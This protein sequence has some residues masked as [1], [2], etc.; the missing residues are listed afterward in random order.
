MS[1]NKRDYE[2]GRGKPPAPG[3]E[4]CRRDVKAASR[5]IAMS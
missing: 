2:V 3:R 5:G 4:Q 1:D